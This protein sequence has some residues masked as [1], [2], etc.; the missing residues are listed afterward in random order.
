MVNG[1]IKWYHCWKLTLF[2]W[3]TRP[4]PSPSWW[5]FSSKYTYSYCTIFFYLYCLLYRIWKIYF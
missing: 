1:K 5:Y 2:C 4:S 3:I